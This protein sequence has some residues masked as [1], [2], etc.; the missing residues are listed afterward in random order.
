MLEE[1]DLYPVKIDIPIAWGDMDAFQHV[2]NLVYFRH[3]ESVRIAYFEQI[4]LLEV[5]DRTHIGPILAATQCRY[6]IPLTYPDTV[7]VGARVDAIETDRFVMKYLTVSHRHQRPAAVG[8]GEMVTFD[9]RKN[10]KAQIPDEIRDKILHLEKSI[11]G[12]DLR[13]PPSGLRNPAD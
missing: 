12:E 3:F 5:M 10:R 2:N 13:L 7:T 11:R 4:N 1:L 8:E 6:K 9:Y